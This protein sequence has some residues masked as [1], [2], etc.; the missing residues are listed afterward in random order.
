[1]LLPTLPANEFR[2][3]PV[4][5][6]TPEALV[7]GPERPRRHLLVADLGAARRHRGMEHLPGVP[8]SYRFSAVLAAEVAPASTA[9][10][11]MEAEEGPAVVR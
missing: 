10:R 3:L 1:M 5:A 9:G 6:A 4:R 8:I 2:P 11:H 7:D